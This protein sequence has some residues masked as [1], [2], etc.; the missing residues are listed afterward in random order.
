MIRSLGTKTSSPLPESLALF[1]IH[2]PVLQC[3]HH[4]QGMSNISGT[5]KPINGVGDLKNLKNEKKKGKQP[6]PFMLY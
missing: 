4:K 3:Y 6:S 5:G 1:Q 2:V